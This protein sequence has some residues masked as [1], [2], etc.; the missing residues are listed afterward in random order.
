MTNQVAVVILNWNGKK[1]LETFLPSVYKNS[2]EANLYVI[3]NASTDDSIDFLQKNYPNINRIPLS[4][5]HGFC[6]G[7]NKGLQTVEEEY[8][9]LLNS[10]VEVTPNWIPPIL[11]VFK[12]N[13]N[14]AVVQ[15]KIKSYSNKDYFE[16][17]GAAGGFL[18]YLGYPFCRGRLFHS[19][20]IDQGQYQQ[21][22]DIHWASGACFTI[23]KELYHQLGGFDENFFAHM[24]EIDLCWRLGNQGY[25]IKYTPESTVFHLGGGTLQ[26]VNPFKTFLN[27]RNGLYLLYKNLPEEKLKKIIMKRMILDGLAGVQFLIKLEFKNFMAIIKAHKEFKNK[28][29]LLKE[30]RSYSTKNVYNSFFKDSIVKT[31]FLNGKKK[32]SDLNVIIKTSTHS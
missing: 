23:K 18:D 32:F 2:P 19:I 9:V 24:E 31:Y 20:E 21:E 16:Y 6:G 25:K 13:N 10:D 11:E 8:Y 27:F 29:K 3:D 12:R 22:S 17:A 14:V 5:N 30:K 28:R 4:K 1:H 15:P 7:Y 26:K